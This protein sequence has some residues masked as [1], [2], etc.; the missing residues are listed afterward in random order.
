[1]LQHLLRAQFAL[2]CMLTTGW[3]ALAQCE[4]P[5]EFNADLSSYSVECLSDLPTE[6][7]ETVTANRGVTAC[8]YA[9]QRQVDNTCIATTALGTGED[10]A[11]VLF[12][13]DGD[14]N[15]DRYFVPTAEGLTLTQFD[16]GVAQVSGEVADIDNPDAK[17]TIQIVYDQGVS[18]ADW[19]GGFKHDMSCAPTTDITDAWNIYILNPGLSYLLGTGDLDGTLLTL[20]HAPSSEYFGFQVGEMAND[21]NCNYGAGGWFSYEGTLNGQ[22]IQLSLIHI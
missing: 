11:I 21:R 12:D 7:D 10:G 8:I 15:D 6:C 17:L 18:G 4:D 1:M 13:V 20:N 16:N 19:T 2:L 5:I 14:P 3:A 9:E 22:A